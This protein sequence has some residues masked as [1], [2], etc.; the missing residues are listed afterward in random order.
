MRWMFI[1]IHR[2]VNG[3]QVQI[4]STLRVKVDRIHDNNGM[5]NLICSLP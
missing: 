5:I 3:E 1:V 4:G 2:V